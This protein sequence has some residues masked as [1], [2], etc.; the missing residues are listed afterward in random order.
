MLFNSR[1]KL[2]PGKMKSRWSGPYT[3]HKVFPHGAIKMKNQNNG[4][5]FK[6]NW[7]RLKP[8]HQRQENG[9]VE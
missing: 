5:T 3:V 7:K 4:Y 1:L 8:Y 6:V 9:L 2:F